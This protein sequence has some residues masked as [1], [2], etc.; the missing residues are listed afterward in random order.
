MNFSNCMYY[1]VDLSRLGRTKATTLSHSKQ[2]L[3]RYI[4]CKTACKATDQVTNCDGNIKMQNRIPTFHVVTSCSLH[5]KPYYLNF[6]KILASLAMQ[7]YLCTCA[8]DRML[9][10]T[11]LQCYATTILTHRDVVASVHSDWDWEAWLDHLGD[12]RQQE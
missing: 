6:V 8:A 2:L 11:K 9:Q 3:L 1:N 5:H 7:T 12:L 4:T 10:K